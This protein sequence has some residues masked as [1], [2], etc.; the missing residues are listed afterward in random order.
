M[1]DSVD[2]KVSKNSKLSSVNNNKSYKSSNDNKIDDLS[3]YDNENQTHFDRKG[4][5]ADNIDYNSLYGTDRPLKENNVQEN[6][7]N[8]EFKNK[9]TLTNKYKF[10]LQ[11]EGIPTFSNNKVDKK[12]NKV[13]ENNTK[14]PDKDN[15]VIISPK[16][17]TNSLN[18]SGK[19]MC[20]NNIDYNYFSSSS[21]LNEKFESFIK[22]HKTYY[23]FLISTF[24]LLT[25][26]IVIEVNSKQSSKEIVSNVSSSTNVKLKPEK[27]DNLKD[28]EIHNVNFVSIKK[29]KGEKS[30]NSYK[31][32][33]LF[34]F[35]FVMI[36]E[37]SIL[38][39]FYYKVS[40]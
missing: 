8:N 29:N 26:Y 14:K 17:S 1:N 25:M 38:L 34:L 10:T 27:I 19:Y 4:K 15:I 40:F 9:E 22:M 11:A 6:I 18:N 30:E 39:I 12:E 36:V 23:Y 2:F 32:N 13:I 20:L 5:L 33:L 21:K 7:V 24:I 37:K 28:S 16:K 31:R 35:V 3:N